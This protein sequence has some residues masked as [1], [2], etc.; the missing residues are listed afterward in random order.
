MTVVTVESSEAW[1]GIFLASLQRSDSAVM[2]WSTHAGNDA[3]ILMCRGRR[4]AA[5]VPSRQLSNILVLSA[6]EYFYVKFL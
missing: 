5:Q 4:A 1:L 2:G 6:S 3:V